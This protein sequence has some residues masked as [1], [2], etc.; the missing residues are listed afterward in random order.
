TRTV[1]LNAENLGTPVIA[2][3]DKGRGYTCSHGD[4]EDYLRF[5]PY[6]CPLF[7]HTKKQHDAIYQLTV[8]T[9]AD[10]GEQ[11]LRGTSRLAAVRWCDRALDIIPKH[12]GK[13]GA[14][15][16]ILA[17][18]AISRENVLA[19]GDGENDIEMLRYAGMGIAMG[20]APDAVKAS[21][22]YVTA[23]CADAGVQS[24]LMNLGY[25]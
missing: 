23:A 7:D 5:S 11:L 24:A 25:I 1:F 19:F 16:E 2:A 15:R 4:L 3:T 8:P 18:Y 12:C 10:I 14:I 17:H 22:D 20:N 6:P 9:H 21:A 13:A